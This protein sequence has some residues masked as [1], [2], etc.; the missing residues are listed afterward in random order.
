MDSSWY[1][2]I[3]AASSVVSQGIFI[4]L[5]GTLRGRFCAPGAESGKIPP[6]SHLQS[7]TSW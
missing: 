4:Y 7:V 2:K 1:P 6:D 3:S 5:A